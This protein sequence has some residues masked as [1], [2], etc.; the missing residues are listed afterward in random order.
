[1]KTLMT[2]VALTFA[3]F[4]SLAASVSFPESIDV[5]GVNG[6]SQFSNHQI[7]LTKGDNLIELKYYD[8]FEANADDSGAWVKS[9]PLYLLMNAD[10]QDQYQ[11]FTP[12]IDT[13]EEAYDFIENPVLT[14]TNTAGKEK[15]VALLTHHQLMAK[16][17]FAKQ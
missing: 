11:A 2:A 12:K 1:M 14:L 4:T 10:N 16:L 15:E 6:K 8:I 7:E 3:S 5:T 9:Q 17:L 13:E